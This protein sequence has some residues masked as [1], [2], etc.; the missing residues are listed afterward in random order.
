MFCHN[1][2]NNNTIAMWLKRI[3]KSLSLCYFNQNLRG[4]FKSLK[5]KILTNII[6]VDSNNTYVL[7]RQSSLIISS[8][9]K[10]IGYGLND[11]LFKIMNEF[12]I[13]KTMNFSVSF[14]RNSV[15]CVTY[16]SLFLSLW[17]FNIMMKIACKNFMDDTYRPTFNP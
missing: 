3:Q 10:N 8:N 2:C 5:F 17:C 9:H 16:F 15:F 13:M 11:L 1:N 7:S 12:K 14:L 4:S 6:V